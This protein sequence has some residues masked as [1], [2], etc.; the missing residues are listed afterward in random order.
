MAF[1]ST[2]AFMP[3]LDTPQY[4][5]QNTVDAAPATCQSLENNTFQNGEELVYKIYYNINFVWIPAGEVTFKVDDEGSRYHFS[6]EG[7]TY[8]S[9]EWFYKAYNKLDS[10]VDKSTFLPHTSIRWVKENRYRLYDHVQFDQKGRS[11][12]FERG[13][14]KDAISKRGNVKLNDCMHDILSAVYYSRTIDYSN[15]KTGQDYPMKV[16]LDE[17]TYPLKYRYM[18]KEE[19]SIH[20]LGKYSTM[21]FVPQLVAGNVFNENSQMKIWATNDANKIPLQIES[22]VAVGTVK[23]VLKSY[24]GLKYPLSAK[25]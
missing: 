10:Y 19:K 1:G 9:Y 13:D 20:G 4:Q 2:M 5:P 25:K 3:H 21:K 6:A 24:K 23:V 12:Q 11:A 15:A 22:P 17:E 14:T 7:K 8:S 16:M 18:G